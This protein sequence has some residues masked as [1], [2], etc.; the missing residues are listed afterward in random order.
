MP[1]SKDTLDLAPFP[2]LKWT[3]Y[4]WWEGK[5]CLPAWA[6]FRSRGAYGAADAD[7]PSDG[8]ARISVTPQEPATN[9]TPSEAQRKAFQFQIDHGTEIV[10]AVLS[11]LPQ[12]YNKLRD[13]WGL[14]DNDI[15]PEVRNP[16]RF[17]HL[18]GLHQIHVHPYLREGL[19]Y[20]GLEF[21]C[22]WDEEHGFG[23]M[24]HGLRVV[25][26][27]SADTSFA[28]KPDEAQNL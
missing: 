10:A 18:I 16:E 8:S 12:Y 22:T 14:H 5:A 7:T 2:K 20:V 26:I 13:N 19:A 28:W 4:D 17:R 27:G 11:A 25:E 9:R 15:M 6:G 21:G 24:L 23:V 1:S 3:K